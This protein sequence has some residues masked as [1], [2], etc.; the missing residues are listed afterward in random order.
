MSSFQLWL[1]YLQPYIRPELP[2]LQLISVVALVTSRVIIELSLPYLYPH[3]G[4][5]CPTYPKAYFLK[6]SENHKYIH[7][8]T[9]IYIPF[10]H[11]DID[12]NVVVG[13]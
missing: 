12:S 10:M 3:Y 1:P 6:Y 5:S 8:H 9:Y 2:Y 7:T 13:C 4:F 11:I